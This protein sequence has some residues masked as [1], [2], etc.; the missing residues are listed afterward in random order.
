MTNNCQPMREPLNNWLKLNLEEIS[1]AAQGIS[2]ENAGNRATLHP[3]QKHDL[4]PETWFHGTAKTQ[5]KP[6]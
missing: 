3:L 4:S 5:G 6:G 2:K 1:I